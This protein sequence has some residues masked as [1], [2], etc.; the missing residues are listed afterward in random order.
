MT[1]ARRCEWAL[2][3]DLM[4]TY[5]DEV[6]GVPQ[7]DPISLFE[8][9]VLEGAQAGLSWRTILEKQEGYRRAFAG[10]DPRAVSP[11]ATTTSSG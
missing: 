1:A 3:S 9:L 6:W 10:F 11:S 4:V 7:R 2:G 8:F 5:H